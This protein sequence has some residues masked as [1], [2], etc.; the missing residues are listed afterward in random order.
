MYAL[1]PRR[2]I[3]PIVPTIAG[4][5]GLVAALAIGLFPGA[6]LDRLVAASGLSPILAALS[7][8]LVRATLAV[9][10]GGL[11]ALLTGAVS[12]A[13]VGR[14]ALAI[15]TSVRSSDARADKPVPILRR[16]DAHPDAPARRPVFAA[17]D[18]GTP[19]L[20]VA[21]DEDPREPA[22]RLPADLDQPLAA[23]D[24]EAILPTPRSPAQPLAPLARLPRPQLIDPGDRF[25][26]F[27]LSAPDPSAD[28]ATDA[29]EPTAT[30]HALLDRLE[31]GFSR[32][33]RAPTPAI[34]PSDGLQDALGALRQ[35]AAGA[36][37]GR[38]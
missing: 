25:E 19:L 4:A 18:L 21:V 34:R 12:H 30:I 16:A 38:R 24:P 35:L 11:V 9:I 1:S 8:P 20:D 36:S 37:A 17:S 6:M 2:L 32:A 26:T 10:A 33:E 14:R 15:A 22:L 13:L 28:H 29:P 3:L 5:A 31:R 23:F 27:A 7:L